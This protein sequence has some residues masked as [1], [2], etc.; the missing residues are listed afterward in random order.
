[1]DLPVKADVS[2]DSLIVAIDGPAGV[3]KSTVAKRLAVT[4]GL[5]YIS[6]GLMYRAVALEALRRGVDA[7]DGE[8]L[9]KIAGDLD[10]GLNT[11]ESPPELAIDGKPPDRS[12]E[13]PEVEAVV[14]R[15][16]RHPGV[17]AILRER[18][19]VLGRG[20]CIMEGRDIG[21]VVFPEADL[22]VLLQAHPEIRTRRRERERGH[23][24]MGEV[25]AER[26]R[27]DAQTTPLSPSAD[28]H[29]LDTTPMSPDEVY[30]SILS[31]IEALP[32]R[33]GPDR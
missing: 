21:S 18:Q 11:S 10:F 28:T 12:L 3:G 19:R 2:R 17:R 24:G 8:A 15:V 1:M 14:S 5:P 32:N 6:T 23:H 27:V 7:D 20:G 13:S 4:L 31:L 22:K 16:S 26:D 25:V 33:E 30:R 9:A 29:T